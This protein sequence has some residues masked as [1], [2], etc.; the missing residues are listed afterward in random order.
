MRIGITTSI[1]L[2]KSHF[3]RINLYVENGF[4][5]IELDDR[6]E[7]FRPCHIKTAKSYLKKGISFSVHSYVNNLFSKE[8]YFRKADEFRLFAEME[9][10]G[11]I[12]AKIVVF[13]LDTR[14]KFNSKTISF[15]KKAVSFAKKRKICLCIENGHGK[16]FSNPLT[17]VNLCKKT[18]LNLCLDLGHLN[19]STQGN[20]Q[21]QLEFINLT[22]D[23]IKHVHIH[24]N[25]SEKDSHQVFLKNK[26]F[27]LDALPKKVCLVIEVKNFGDAL[28]QKKILLDY[29]N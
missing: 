12:A 10:A 24:D 27:L 21:K 13:H 6:V 15:L 1:S 7:H 14:K 5:F 19:V 23:Y 25:N 2:P 26:L 22:F 28:K 9:F 11:K 8:N 18:G 29:L 16:K 3:N 17:F 20:L 4:D